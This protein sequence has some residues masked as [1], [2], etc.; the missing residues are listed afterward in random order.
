MYESLTIQI[1]RSSRSKLKDIKLRE[2]PTQLNK[3]ISALI[4][5]KIET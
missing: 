3:D 4:N 5:S 2:V 1:D